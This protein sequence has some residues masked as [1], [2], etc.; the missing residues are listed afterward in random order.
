MPAESFD[1]KCLELA[2]HFLEDEPRLAGREDALAAWVQFHVEM[3]IN[4][5]LRDLGE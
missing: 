4:A 1:P 3:W 5:E 2:T